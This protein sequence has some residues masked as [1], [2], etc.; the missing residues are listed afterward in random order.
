MADYWAR[1]GQ[2]LKN[3]L[4]NTAYLAARFAKAFSSEEWGRLAGLWHDLGKYQQE[5]QDKL[6]GL[7]V[8]VEHSGAGAA[9]A[10]SKSR[11]IGMALAF[12]IAGHHA[13]LTNPTVSERGQPKPLKERLKENESILKRISP[14]L[15]PE[16]LWLE[17]PGAP[18]FLKP[19]PDMPITDKS[20]LARRGE[21]WTR[22][23]FSSLVDADRLDS[24]S[25]ENPDQ[26]ARRGKYATIG[27]LCQRLDD[28]IDRKVADLSKEDQARPVNRARARILEACRRAA[29]K[30]LGIFALTVP[31]G[32]GKTLSAMSFALRQAEKNNLRRVIVVIPYTSIIEQNADEYRQA[33]GTE[34]V[35][36]HHSS[37]SPDVQRER[38]GE[39][40]AGRHELAAENW[41]APIIVTT[42]VQFFETIF[43][44]RPSRC[45]KLHNVARSVIILDEVQSLP[46]EYLLSI[47]E[48]LNELV[49]HYGCSVILSTATPPA[50]RSRENFKN[51]LKN[52]Q[53]IIPD[54]G[55]L[56]VKLKRVEYKW[57]DLEA[58]PLEWADLAQEVAGYE[59]ALVVVHRRKD[60]RD[61]ARLLQGLK[62]RDSIFHLSALM[63]PAHRSAK[64]AQ[65]KERLKNNQ[66]CLL[67]STQLIEAGVDVDFPVVYRALGGLDS[68]VQAAGRCNR[69]GRLM[70][71][72]GR[73]IVFQA[74]TRPPSGTP[75][76]GLA[77]ME[78]MLRN[79][80]GKLDP[81][82]P[83]VFEIYFRQLY[84]ASNL[85]ARQIQTY[86]Q[87]FKFADVDRHFHLI[88][89]GF[90]QTLVVPYGQARKKI[91][92]L[93]K[94]GPN[95]DRLRSLQPYT[96]QVYPQ[97]FNR[98][99]T[100]GA[101]EEIAEGIYTLTVPFANQY[102]DTF[103]LLDEEEPQ[104]DAEALVVSS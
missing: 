42:T 85:D 46:P 70:E 53:D 74:P 23:L 29:L 9:L 39:E 3:H 88:E 7:A 97:T 16:I 45:R 98:L 24:E 54:P 5:F 21:L 93:Q 44:N 25:S 33:M 60:A 89:D 72:P 92:E 37:L 102:D 52:V 64:L 36:E 79:A 2:L 56:S 62:P 59:R 67:V 76:K 68:V 15:P 103:G 101:V 22:F 27:V 80:G 1:P 12:A 31:T 6:K 83:Q 8:S 57:P 71:G 91:D 10:V 90:T 78:S 49:D 104:A 14:D 47:V 73:V 82:D 69:E 48:A 86:R 35:L 28:F 55:D 4:N 19:T 41:D 61:L 50:L 17:V 65:V 63:C 66:T 43:S 99:M 18:T 95:R 75:L 26:A 100:V 58:P 77:A 13:G 34:N 81:T 30:M 38:Y 84:F 32:G 11:S 20:L 96:I 87:D 40:I 51:G 94:H